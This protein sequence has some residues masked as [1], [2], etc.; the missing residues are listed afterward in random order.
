MPRVHYKHCEAR[1][2]F[3]NRLL[4]RPA[5]PWDTVTGEANIGNFHLNYNANGYQVYEMVDK[6]GSTQTLM[7]APTSSR[8]F[9]LLG[10][11]LEAFKYRKQVDEQYTYYCGI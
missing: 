8:L 7:S 10:A 3:I 9:D 4:G 2:A 6:H 5:C 1:L 11:F